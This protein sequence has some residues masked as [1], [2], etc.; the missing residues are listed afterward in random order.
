MTTELEDAYKE[1]LSLLEEKENCIKI[2]SEAEKA[3]NRLRELAGEYS[4]LGLLRKQRQRCKE[5]TF[6]IYD[7]SS[8]G[9][10]SR[11]RRIISVDAKWIS[12]KSDGQEEFIRYK[13][14]TGK[15]ERGRENCQ[16]IDVAKSL[17][18]WDAR[19][20]YDDKFERVGE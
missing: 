12:L 16:T 20:V 6:P 3:K 14:D 5:L 19:T 18:I 7:D 8:S 9:W 13:R 1:Y 2:L 15:I 4:K 10:G 11:I 17:E